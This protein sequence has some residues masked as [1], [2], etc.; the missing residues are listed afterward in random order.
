MLTDEVAPQGFIALKLKWIIINYVK[1][2][3]SNFTSLYKKKLIKRK[4]GDYE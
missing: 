1:H 2:V 4:L 3:T